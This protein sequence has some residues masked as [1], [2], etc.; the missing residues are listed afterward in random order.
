MTQ[1]AVYDAVNAIERRHRPYLLRTRFHRNASKDAAVATA[2]YRVLSNI[3]ATVPAT[4]PVPEQGG[5]V[6]VAGYG[7][8][9]LARGDT[10]HPA[11]TEGIAAGNAAADAMIAARQGDG[12]F[13]PSQWMSNSDPGT[14]S[15]C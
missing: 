14:G 5:L 7:V 2:A 10:G 6:A 3:V 11:K 12:R 1:G 9:H 8:R 15:R 13:G 4:H